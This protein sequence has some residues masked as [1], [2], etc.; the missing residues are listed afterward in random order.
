MTG[1]LKLAPLEFLLRM[2]PFARLQSLIYSIWSGE[3]SSL[4][5]DAGL[6]TSNLNMSYAVILLLILFLGNGLLAFCL[7]VSSF[8]TNK[9]VGALTMTVC[10]NVKQCITIIL[11]VV[12]FN[13]K[14]GSLNAA[15]LFVTTCGA[16]AYSFVELHSKRSQQRQRQVA[17]GEV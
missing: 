4:A 9:L 2:S 14:V 15:G 7:N 11:G 3:I 1:S 8:T 6:V 10:G 12:L 13:V 17:N 5:T 16:A